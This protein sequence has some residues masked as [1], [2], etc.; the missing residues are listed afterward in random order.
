MSN[1]K[2]GYSQYDFADLQHQEIQEKIKYARKYNKPIICE[3]NFFNPRSLVSAIRNEVFYLKSYPNDGVNHSKDCRFYND[4]TGNS[5]SYSAFKYDHDEGIIDVKLDAFFMKKTRSKL[6]KSNVSVHSNSKPRN[7][8]S[9]LGLLRKV[10]YESSLYIYRPDKNYNS[11]FDKVLFRN[12]RHLKSSRRN[13]EN[14][15]SLINPAWEMNV[16]NVTKKITVDFP[17]IVGILDCFELDHENKKYYLKL[18]GYKNTIKITEEDYNNYVRFCNG[19]AAWQNYEKSHR[20]PMDIVICQCE[21]KKIRNSSN[22]FLS[23]SEGT[24]IQSMAVTDT[25]IPYDSSYERKMA[26]Y[27]V[28]NQRSFK[29]PMAI[30]EDS[31]LMPDFI[32]TDIYKN[33]C[34]EIWGMSNNCDYNIRKKEKIKM[35]TDQNIRLIQWEPLKEKSMPKLPDIF[36]T[37]NATN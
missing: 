33:A 15:L 27:L 16:Y 1:F 21:I 30:L 14:F 32:I 12:F 2:I 23:L 10:W 29:K 8:T 19:K 4:G 31:K 34:I 5:S 24:N 17:I 3:C 36:T 6:S 13:S 37:S 18:K 11:V 28:D 25:Y 20:K 7:S 22:K 26:D 9:L 35:Y